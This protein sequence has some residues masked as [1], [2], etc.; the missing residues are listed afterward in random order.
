MTATAADRGTDS[1]GSSN[2]PDTA[3]PVVRRATRHQRPGWRDP[4]ILVGM[5]IVAAS[6]LAGVKIL[7]GA[8]DTV[9]VWSL[10]SDLP[11]GS[12]VSGDDVVVEQ[13]RFSSGDQADHYL[14]AERPLPRRA[15]LDR[16]VD[17][18]ELLPRMALTGIGQALVEVPVPVAVDDVPATVRQ[19]SVVDVWVTPQTTATA[20]KLA[21]ATLVLDDVVVV[22]AP[23]A[24]DSLAPSG[25]RQVIVGMSRDRAGDLGSALGKTS[26][27]HVVIT[28]QG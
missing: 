17:A 2:G 14:S 27:G 12:R 1:I 18:G 15:V 7:T 22:A 21:D 26:A 4:R 19:G 9:A 13:I 8:D 10:R 6:V 23:R 24:Q 11:A 28:R 16:A 20:D 3:P 5:V 25:T